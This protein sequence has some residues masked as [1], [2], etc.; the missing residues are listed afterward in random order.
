M[1][2][3]KSL[4][5][6]DLG[7]QGKEKAIASYL[8]PHTQGG[9]LVECGPGSTQETLQSQL[10]EHHLS[11]ED[12]SDV[13]LTHIHLDHAGA[14]GWL[15][16][17]GARIHVHHIG[18]PHMIN[19]ERLLASAERIYGDQMDSLWG[20]FLPVPEK[21]ISVLHDGDEIE[22]GE[23]I[24]R[25]F[26]TPGHAYH[27][28]A[29]LWEDICFSGDIGG[30]RISTPGPKH[31]RIPM[32][33]PSLHL[34]KW[35][36]SIEKLQKMQFSSIACTHFGIFPDVEWHLNA[37]LR[38]IEAAEKW[39]QETMSEDVSLERL[40]EEFVSWAMKR[41]VSSGMKGT[42]LTSYEKANPS[43]MSADGLFR[44]WK[45]HIQGN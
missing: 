8:I 23:H 7:F 29:Y 27:H 4:Y 40:R 2:A 42:W 43:A 35:R 6:L 18:A 1:A 37:V 11:V 20:T 21:K 13:L 25:A 33:P 14:A 32:P 45:K 39:I 12:I 41:S 10:S 3:N 28:M 34:Q 19:P 31:L 5:T 44:Y 36:T 26:D 16:K 30:V 24:F 15:A 22:I 38:E 17:K 9:I